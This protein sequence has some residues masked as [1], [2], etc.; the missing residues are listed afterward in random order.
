MVEMVKAFFQ[1]LSKEIEVSIIDVEF[2]GKLFE[3]PKRRFGLC[4]G[5]V[6]Y[7]GYEEGHSD[8]E[9]VLYEREDIPVGAKVAVFVSLEFVCEVDVEEHRTKIF[10][11]SRN[12]DSFP[13]IRSGDVAEVYYGSELKLRG[14]VFRDH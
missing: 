4:R 1:K 2:E 13:I 6:E 8:F 9:F 12:G 14:E 3:V 5:E 10:L 11:Q 7:T